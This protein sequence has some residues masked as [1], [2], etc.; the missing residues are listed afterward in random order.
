MA[1]SPGWPSHADSIAILAG[2]TPP[3]N[4]GNKVETNDSVG[5]TRT[6][7]IGSRDGTEIRKKN[8]AIQE[9]SEFALVSIPPA[10]PLLKGGCCRTLSDDTTCPSA[11]AKA[12]DYYY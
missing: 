8:P 5:S 6:W 7:F 12:P 2:L 4:L 11:A 9:I 3:A 10:V 1:E